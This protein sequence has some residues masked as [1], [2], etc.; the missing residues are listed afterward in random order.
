[1]L[2]VILPDL[3]HTR[4]WYVLYLSRYRSTFY[5]DGCSLAAD[6]SGRCHSAGQATVP[7]A[8]APSRSPHL[9]SPGTGS[10]GSTQW[11]PGVYHS[12]RR[13]E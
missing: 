12:S 2:T 11:S 9:G 7:D 10:P 8:S 4:P 5:D 3:G 13:W 1:M 6:T